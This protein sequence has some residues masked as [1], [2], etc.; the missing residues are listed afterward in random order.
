MQEGATPFVF[1]RFS[2]TRRRSAAGIDRTQSPADHPGMARSFACLLASLLFAS[3]SMPAQ[4]QRSTAPRCLTVE[5]HELSD[6]VIDKDGSGPE[7]SITDKRETDLI[8]WLGPR[9]LAVQSGRVLRVWDYEAGVVRRI[10]RTERT[11]DEVSVL[12]EVAFVQIEMR[13]RLELRSALRSADIKLADEWT[14]F[15]MSITFG[16]PA[17]GDD[18]TLDRAEEKGEVRF[19]RAGR[20]VTNWRL[21]D[22]A[23]DDS[24]RAMF[25][26]V[27]QRQTHI[28]PQAMSALVASGR[29]PSDLVFR[30][31][32]PGMDT[33]T[34]WQLAG[35]R[36]DEWPGGIEGLTRTFGGGR[37]GRIAQMVWVPDAEGVPKR[38]SAERF[39]E[40][41]EAAGKERRF[42]DAAMLLLESNL[43]TDDQAPLL[44]RL[45]ADA[46]AKEQ[47]A[48]FTRPIA[49]SNR[50]PDK[51]LALFDE[52]DRSKL[53]RPVFV[54][55][56]RVNALRQKGEVDDARELML[57]TLE[58]SPW[59]TMA[60]K[61]LGDLFLDGFATEK[62]WTAWE[63][64]R[65]IAPGHRCWREVEEFEK[66]LRRE[67][68]ER[69]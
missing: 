31:R 4:E 36:E 20:V 51:A 45:A 13:N 67:F 57:A 3:C 33:T 65:R 29:L 10:E 44:R 26:R 64:G 66:K 42:A 63:L 60:Y 48:S 38:L 8:V 5:Y 58:A 1:T 41:A 69:L 55:V 61:D 43:T 21:S 47:M 52:L 28:H 56:F 68:A 40:L 11:Y 49:L 34:R 32:S 23:L 35:V 24:Q 15:D 30:H 12:H 39:T 27:L 59:I 9:R 18:V 6:V 25:S 7:P 62:A 19:S 17:E 16:W 46:D 50:E 2:S 22:H 53:S 54:D 37:F 14:P